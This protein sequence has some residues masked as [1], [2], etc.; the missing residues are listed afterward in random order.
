MPGRLSNIKIASSVKHATEY[1]RLNLNQEQFPSMTKQ[2]IKLF[3]DT[4]EFVIK[5]SKPLKA[6]KKYRGSKRRVASRNVF[7]IMKFK[8]HKVD[9]CGLGSSKLDEKSFR[10][11]K[12][13]VYNPFLNSV[14]DIANFSGKNSGGDQDFQFKPI[15]ETAG[16]KYKIIGGKK[17]KQIGQPNPFPEQL[18]PDQHIK[19]KSMKIHT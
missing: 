8:D 15:M 5:N 11:D 18:Y 9:Y 4:Y 2:P 10:G 12:R 17:N 7:D 14:G 1:G 16:T 6:G 3:E 13:L 19:Y